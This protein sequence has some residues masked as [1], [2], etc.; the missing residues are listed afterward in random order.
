MEGVRESSGSDGSYEGGGT[1]HASSAGVE[2]VI[3]AGSCLGESRGSTDPQILSSRDIELRLYDVRIGHAK[4]RRDKS[5]EGTVVAVAA[6]ALAARSGDPKTTAV[7]AGSA[8]VSGVV[9]A[10]RHFEV[11]VLEREKQMVKDGRNPHAPY[12]PPELIRENYQRGGPY[13]CLPPVFLQDNGTPDYGG[14]I[15]KSDD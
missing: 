11:Q 10:K 1:G 8:A 5:L 6:T 12:T 7:A 15:C 14:C 13:D 3:I 4:E 2:A 9:T